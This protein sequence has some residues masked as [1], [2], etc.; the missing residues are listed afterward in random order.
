MKVLCWNVRRANAASD[1]WSYLE[2]VD[3]DIALLQEVSAPSPNILD[4]YT[5]VMRN[6]AGKTGKPQRFGTAILT[7]YPII[8]DATRLAASNNW[9]RQQAEFFA[10]NLV[11]TTLHGPSGPLNVVSVYSPAWPVARAAWAIED[12][13]DIKLAA[14]PDVWCTEILWDL[15]RNTLPGSSGEWI[16]GGDYNSCETFDFWADGDRGNREIMARLNALGLFDALRSR[17]GR[18][19]PTYRRPGSDALRNQLD[20]VY[21]SR[22]MIDRLREC[23][24][25]DAAH[26]FGSR[27]SDHLPILAEFG[28][29]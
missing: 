13:R 11:Y 14:N 4:R 1:V 25:G 19:V 20:H 27:L 29:I 15:L 24:V 7:K 10:G 18:R 21:V 17:H 5:T 22:P 12:V 26:I 23:R 28:A 9:V 16:V 3:P 2:S 6:A 8:G